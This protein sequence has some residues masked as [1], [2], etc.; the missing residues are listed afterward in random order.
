VAA[1]WEANKTAPEPMSADEINSWAQWALSQA[2]RIDP[3]VNGS[4]KTRPTEPEE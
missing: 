1:I 4:Y 3:I 2:A